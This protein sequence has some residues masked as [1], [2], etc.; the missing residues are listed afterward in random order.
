MVS[1]MQGFLESLTDEGP[2][3]SRIFKQMCMLGLISKIFSRLNISLRWLTSTDA[4]AKANS[5]QSD[6][7]A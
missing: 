7:Y 4:I 6:Y 1:G 3:A 2:D 5:D